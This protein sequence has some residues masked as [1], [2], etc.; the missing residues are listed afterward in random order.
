MLNPLSTHRNLAL[1]FALAATVVLAPLAAPASAEAAAWNADPNHSEVR[2]AV[3]HFFTPV[4]GRFGEF[5]ISLA[6]DAENPA[7]SS[8]EAKIAIASIDTGNERR[9]GHLRSGDF[10]E[11]EQHPYMTFKSSSVEKVGENEFVARGPLTIKGTYK[12]IELPITLLGVKELPEE[13]SQMF[14]GIKQVA[15]FKAETTIDRGD[16]GV[17]VGDW[18]S[19]LVIGDEVEIEIF[20]EANRK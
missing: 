10:F 15:S 17:G 6:F 7:N 18:A 13:M 11:A 16:F 2:F 5:E 9:D 4:T 14:G 1:G 20:V 12:E 19:D 3:D 8:V